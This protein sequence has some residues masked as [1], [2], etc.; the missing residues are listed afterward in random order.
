[1]RRKQDKEFYAKNK[2]KKQ[3]N[4][5]KIDRFGKYSRKHVRITLDLI[6]RRF[7]SSKKINNF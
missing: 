1:M 5:E 6:R 2:K 4:K 7:L 3:Q